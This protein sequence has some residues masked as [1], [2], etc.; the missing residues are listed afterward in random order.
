MEKEKRRQKVR[1][2]QGNARLASLLIVILGLLCGGGWIFFN[3]GLYLLPEEM[4]E[5]ALG[6]DAV[7]RVLPQARAAESGSRSQGAGRDLTFSCH[8]TT[9]GDSIL[10]GKAQVRSLSREEWLEYYRG[11]G[12]R[13]QVI[14]VSVGDIEALALTESRATSSV[15]VPCTPPSVPSYEAS[16]PYAVIG[17]TWV[18]G[19]AEATGEPLR[20][21]LTDFAYQL[22]VHA[23][24]LAECKAPR[25]FPK[26]LPRYE[27]R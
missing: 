4:C 17:E 22:A 27:D 3:K 6:R 12:G 23:Y 14:R 8:V 13:H 21:D 20:Q 16:Q 7:K 26:E 10:S 18:Y 11:P 1:V 15:Y 25:D 24:Q 19:Q 5:G 9:S 2:F